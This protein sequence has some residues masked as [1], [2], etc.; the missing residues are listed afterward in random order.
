MCLGAIQGDRQRWAIA[1]ESLDLLKGMRQL[2]NFTESFTG[3]F[4][5]KF[6]RW[7]HRQQPNIFRLT[8]C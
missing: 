2:E 5:Q 3:K 7:N 8:F 6:H 4:H 1:F